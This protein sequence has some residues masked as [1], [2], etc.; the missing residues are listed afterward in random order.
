MLA[1]YVHE[2]QDQKTSA[3][4]NHHCRSMV[5]LSYV[6]GDNILVSPA[7]NGRQLMACINRPLVTNPSS[8]PPPGGHWNGSREH[9]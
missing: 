7:A 5:A 4:H 8:P 6:R 3:P 2:S 1:S 9:G